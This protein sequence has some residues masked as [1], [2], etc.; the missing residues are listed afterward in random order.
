MSVDYPPTTEYTLESAHSSVEEDLASAE[1]R[2]QSLEDDDD[3]TDKA[4]AKAR[5][6]LNTLQ[7]HREAL[8]W[9]IDQW[10]KDAAVAL[11]AFTA[12]T[13]ARTLDTINDK[14]VGSV[15]GEETRV[16]LIASSLDSAPWLDPDDDLVGDYRNTGSLPPALQDWLDSLVTD[17]NDLSSGN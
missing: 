1:D 11:T 7:N 10:S 2:L 4:L 15:G 8:E 14:T 6:R 16:W 3:A 17:L 12:Q 13:R 9:G 5:S